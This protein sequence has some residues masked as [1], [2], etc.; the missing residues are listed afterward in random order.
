MSYELLQSQLQSSYDKFIVPKVKTGGNSAKNAK[1]NRQV[2]HSNQKKR[3]GKRKLSA[4]GKDSLFG[5]SE[6]RLISK[7]IFLE[8]ASKDIT[9]REKRMQTLVQKLSNET[10]NRK[11]SIGDIMK[12]VKIN[13]K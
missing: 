13:K 10:N 4:V 3:T 8:K 7:Q 5:F 1:S 9:H 2:E 11:H 6:R 12:V